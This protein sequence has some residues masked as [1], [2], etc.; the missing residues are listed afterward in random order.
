MGR[1]QLPNGPTYVPDDSDTAMQAPEWAKFLSTV[2][3]SLNLVALC[4]LDQ[5]LLEEV[6]AEN[7]GLTLL[8]LKKR[9]PEH[10]SSHTY[11]V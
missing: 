1:V 6:M 4:D 10:T 5:V 3:G 2:D 7:R 9:S 11:R 8:D